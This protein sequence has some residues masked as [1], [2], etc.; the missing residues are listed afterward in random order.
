MVAF[1]GDSYHQV[2]AYTTNTTTRLSLVLEQYKI[3][4][5]GHLADTL[6]WIEESKEQESPF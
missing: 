2:K 1:R 6:E 4:D 3:R 5:D